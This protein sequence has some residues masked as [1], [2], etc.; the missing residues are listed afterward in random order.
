MT[1]RELAERYHVSKQAI[2][3]RL[4]AE[5]KKRGVSL[6]VY[7]DV[8][9]HRITP[10]GEAVLCEVYSTPETIKAPQIEEKQPIKE[11]DA[12]VDKLTKRVNELTVEVDGLR[13]QVEELKQE[14]EK[15]YTALTN[16]QQLHAMALRLLPS[17]ATDAD[18]DGGASNNDGKRSRLSRAWSALRGK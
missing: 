4:T 10:E 1:T 12:E 8:N 3:Q 18:Q 17:P 15:L 6:S 7:R 14:K 16:E 9:T 13:A 2:S 11:V 5:A